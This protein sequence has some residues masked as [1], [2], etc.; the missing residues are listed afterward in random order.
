MSSRKA[1]LSLTQAK[2]KDLVDY[3]ATLGFKPAKIRGNDYWYQSPLRE[4]KTAS[5]KINRH[6]N[7]WFDHGSGQG[8]NLVDFGILYHHCTVKE[9][10]Q[11]LDDGFSFH[12]PDSRKVATATNHENRIQ[13]VS[14]GALNSINLLRYLNQRRI[15]E[16][17]ARKYCREVTFSLNDKRYSAIGFRNN[18]GGFELRNPWFKASSSPKAIT[19]FGNDPGSLSVFEGFFDFLSHQTIHKPAGSFL[20]L[21]STSFFEKVR[22]FMEQHKQVHLYLDRDKTGQKLT[23][24]AVKSSARY[25][26]QSSLYEGYKD[27]NEWVQNIGNRKNLRQ[28]P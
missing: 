18:D 9:L 27:L 2:Q 19:T 13:I 25:I 6:R 15:A 4:E 8:G 1:N 7:V 26:D 14:D 17:V 20:V 24:E 16:T 22:P 23:L 11:K 28:K 10:L 21:N 3:L 12:Q 5:F